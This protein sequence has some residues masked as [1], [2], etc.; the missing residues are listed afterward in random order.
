MADNGENAVFFAL[1]FPV[2]DWYQNTSVPS[3][4][5]ISPLYNR[6]QN[7]K[8]TKII[9]LFARPKMLYQQ[10][11]QTSYLHLSLHFLSAFA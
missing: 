11:D 6:K 2:C 1:V 5:S 10:K 7:Y 3:I 9:T 4:L 8:K